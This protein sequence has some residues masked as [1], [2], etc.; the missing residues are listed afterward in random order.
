MSW[1]VHLGGMSILLDKKKLREIADKC[2][3][4]VLQ[5]LSSSLYLCRLILTT[6]LS[7]VVI[8]KLEGV[9]IRLL[10]I[11]KNIMLQKSYL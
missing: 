1:C 6:N 10:V 7:V 8:T 9:V 3:E 4:H 5:R 2:H 11:I